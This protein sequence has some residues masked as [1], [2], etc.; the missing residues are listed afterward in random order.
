MASNRSA[1]I[2]LAHAATKSCTNLKCPTYGKENPIIVLI[3]SEDHPE[4]AY[5]CTVCKNIYNVRIYIKICIQTANCI[6]E[7]VVFH[8]SRIGIGPQLHSDI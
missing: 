8:R 3:T 5:L 4:I 7:A 1:S 6:V 2:T